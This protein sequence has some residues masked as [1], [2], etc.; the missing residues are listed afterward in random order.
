MILLIL[1][2]EEAHRKPMYII[3]ASSMFKRKISP[4]EKPFEKTVMERNNKKVQDWHDRVLKEICDSKGK[5]IAGR[6][7]SEWQFF[8]D[9]EKVT[10]FH[11]A[12]EAGKIK[13]L[14]KEIVDYWVN[15][16]R[17]SSVEDMLDLGVEVIGYGWRVIQDEIFAKKIIDKWERVYGKSDD[18]LEWR[19]LANSNSHLWNIDFDNP[20]WDEEENEVINE[21]LKAVLGIKV[22]PLGEIQE[23]HVSIEKILYMLKAR[24]S[25]N[26]RPFIKAVLQKNNKKVQEWYDKVLKKICDS[27]GKFDMEKIQNEWQVFD[28]AE[29]VINFNKAIDD[30]HVVK[31]SEEI[32]NYWADLLKNSSLQ[33]MLEIGVE[34][35]GYG[36]KIIQDE[37]FIRKTFDKLEKVYSVQKDPLKWRG[38]AENNEYLWNNNHFDIPFW[39]EEEH[40]GIYEKLKAILTIKV[41]PQ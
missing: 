13:R 35:I 36:W 8:D 24:I 39:S 9:A 19:D 7:V 23:K 37:L 20:F 41:S 3:D 32:V 38:L 4:N 34:V 25:S 5:V 11:K 21:K 14:S 40:E 1:K 31:H 29:R 17:K 16:L 30:G 2:M 28:D 10:K 27:K 18:P 22:K 33:D 12:I 26:E 6:V 15:V